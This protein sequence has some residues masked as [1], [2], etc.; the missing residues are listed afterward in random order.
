MRESGGVFLG[1]QVVFV[2]MVVSGKVGQVGGLITQS[3]ES[4]ESKD[5]GRQMSKSER[6]S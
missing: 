5:L 1:A 3:H 4:K 2:Q 6:V